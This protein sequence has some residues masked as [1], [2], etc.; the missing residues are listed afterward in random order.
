MAI[1]DSEGA[2]RHLAWLRTRAGDYDRGTRRRLLTAA[3]IPAALLQQAQQARALVR[4][5]VREALARV[6]VLVAPTAHRPAPTIAAYTAPITSTA[7]AA[8]RFFTRRS[9]TTPAALAGTP[10][11][12]VPCGF[13]ASGLPLSLQVIGRPFEDATVLRVAHAYEQATEW[14]RRRPVS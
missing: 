12:A 6:D 1:C 11:I 10:A 3:L 8:A 2:A 14:H 9:F 5:Q 4:A 13:A 7:E